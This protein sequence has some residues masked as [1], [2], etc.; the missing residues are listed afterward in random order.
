MSKSRILNVT[1]DLD[2]IH[3]ELA[4]VSIGSLLGTPTAL[5]TADVL[6]SHPVPLQAD[7]LEFLRRSVESSESAE[8]SARIE[9]ILFGCMDLKLEEQV[10]P[11]LDML[12]FFVQRGWMHV[13][14]EKIRAS[15]IVPWLQAQSDF[16]KREEMQ[17]ESTIF[18]KG[19]V[20]RILLDIVDI[21][22]RVATEIL[23]FE[24]FALY[25]EE[26]KQV[27]FDEQAALLA[28]YLDD[29]AETYHKRI[30]PWIEEKIGRPFENLSRYHALYLMRIRRFDDYFESSDL[31]ET[32]GRTFRG[33]GFDLPSRSDVMLNI[34]DDPKRNPDGV[35]MAVEIPGEVHVLMKPV[36]GLI[37]VETLL[38][39][40]GHAFFLSHFDP[41]LPLEYRRL[42]RS[43]ALDEAF[44]FLFMDII[45]NRS[46]LTAIV[47]MPAEKADQ[48]AELY[49]T[50]R[51]CL[52]R[53]YIGK[54]LAELEL[55]KKGDPADPGPYCRYLNKATGFVYE[56]EG[57]L[58]DMERDFYALDYLMAW[59]G[60]HVLRTTLENRFGEEWFSNRE[61][62]DFLR[63]ISSSGRRGSLEETLISSCGMPPSLPDFS[64]D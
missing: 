4:R 8:E 21:T 38:H 2:A 6:E 31:E 17:K 47:G 36:G 64:G 44:A 3:R 54:F 23:G 50:K 48:L 1:A 33:L 15:E 9:R 61:A 32:V 52:I 45:D 43:A 42:Y 18:L 22:S 56:P 53:R 57:Y 16:R 12:G 25:C 60:A 62:G 10:S 39:E 24:N 59:A 20:N 29:S 49:K 34:S 63:E 37:D 46:W 35:C 13:G 7:T 40:T 5:T 30:V 55:H 28:R 11:L 14:S 41:G 58:I 19:L 51:L 27:S 26:K